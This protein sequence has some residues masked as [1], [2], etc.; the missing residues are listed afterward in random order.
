VRHDAA[1]PVEGRQQVGVAP[2]G[3]HGERAGR[4]RDRVDGLQPPARRVDREEL[5]PLRRDV[6][7]RPE[8]LDSFFDH[9][10]LSVD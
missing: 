5:P 6:L 7:R 9:V 1:R 2:V 4:R 10:G 3:G 8:L